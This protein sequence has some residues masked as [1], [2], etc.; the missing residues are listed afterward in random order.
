MDWW[1]YSHPQPCVGVLGGEGQ[2]GLCSLS[3]F[4]FLKNLPISNVEEEIVFPLSRFW[5]L[6]VPLPLRVQDEGLLLSNVTFW[7][8]KQIPVFYNL[9][10]SL[11]FSIS[12]CPCSELLEASVHSS[13]RKNLAKRRKCLLPLLQGL[14]PTE[15]Q[16]WPV[17]VQCFVSWQCLDKPKPNY[18]PALITLNGPRDNNLR[19]LALGIPTGFSLKTLY[20]L[21]SWDFWYFQRN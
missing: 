4:P 13:Q 9:E 7:P 19:I 20:R 1:E 8:S 3:P 2:W 17:L 18:G 21:S 12:K 11:K 16:S 14:H 6:V 15:I 10:M 5:P